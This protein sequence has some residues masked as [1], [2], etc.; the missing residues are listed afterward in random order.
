MI[1]NFSEY[2]KTEF[3]SEVIYTNGRRKIAGQTSI[4]DRN[5][6]INESGGQPKVWEEYT[7]AMVQIIT[8]DRSLPAARKLAT[9]IFDKVHGKF[10]VP[11]PLVIVAGITYN[12]IKSAQINGIQVPHYLGDDTEGRPEFTTN[13]QIIYSR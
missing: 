5:V 6:L 12:G 13:Y 3:P 9:D 7:Q 1:Y 8:R 4:P 10:G 11:L 2:L